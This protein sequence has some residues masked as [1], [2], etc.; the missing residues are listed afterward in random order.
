MPTLIDSGQGSKLVEFL[1]QT[2]PFSKMTESDLITL[3]RDFKQRMFKKGEIIFHQGDA[4]EEIFMVAR[5]KVRIFRLAA[6]GNE[7][8]IDIFSVGRILGEFAALDNQDR[9]ASAKAL[10]P[11]TLLSISKH[12]FLG[13]LRAMPDLALG[14]IQLIIAKARW[15]TDFAESLAQ[16]D[17]A[18]RLLHI[19]LHYNERFGEEIET[20]RK[21]V[22]D[23]NLTQSDLA[24][25]VG[26][27]RGWINHLLQDWDKRGLIQYRAGK[28]FI[29]DLSRVI[30]ERDSRIEIK[31]TEEW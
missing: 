8:T 20:G 3:S 7:T 22:L 17:A 23:L 29:L 5:G 10:E 16:Y 28:I 12:K 9:S 31:S 14:M 11:A 13:H 15:T 19:L 4:G 30:A 18:G 25:L 2:A 26:V 27:K 1:R 24:S 6:S 21:Y